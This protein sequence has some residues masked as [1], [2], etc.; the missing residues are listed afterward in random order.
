MSKVTYVLE[1]LQ[2]ITER[3]GNDGWLVQGGKIK[4]MGYMKGNFKTKEDAVSYYDRYNPHMRS[5]NAHNK[6]SSD[7]DP[8]TKLLYIVRNDYLIN[9][10]IDC[11]SIDDNPVYEIKNGAGNTK[12]KWLK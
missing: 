4:H 8:N 9:A 3:E 5:L 7:W 11:F 6:Y 1:V 10:T 2:F 12:F